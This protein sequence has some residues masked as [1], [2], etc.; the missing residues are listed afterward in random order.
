MHRTLPIRCRLPWL[1]VP[2]ALLLVLLQ[3]TPVVRILSGA[4]EYVLASPAGQILRAAITAAALGAMHSRA[5]ATTFIQ[6]PDNPVRG[7]VGTP[8]QVA[9]TYN[10]TPSPP[11]SF[12]VSGTLPP[13][14]RFIPAAALGTIPSGTPAI[15]G[16]PTQ[17]GTFTVHVQ[18]FNAE[19]L[20]NNVQQS[21]EF[22]ITGGTTATAP[23]IG[24]HPQSQTVAP[25]ASV[26]FSVT[27]TGDPPLSYQWQ[28][29]G[30]NL[31]G[32][33][34]ATLALSNVQPGDAGAYRVVV[35]NSAGSATSAAATLAVTTGGAG[36][37]I[38][39]QPQSQTIAGGSTVVFTVAATDATAF[40]WR[41]DGA[42][43]PG[44]TSPM[45]VISGATTAHAGTY[46]CVVTG[47]GG[48]VTSS[49]AVLTVVNTLDFGRLINLSISTAVSAA[50]PLFTVGTVIGGAGTAGAKP[51]LVR[52]VG[53]ALGVFGVD[54]VLADP[55]LE[56]FNALA[57]KEQENERWGG[58]AVLTQAFA[59]VGAFPFP[60][61]S[62][63]AAVF[64]EAFQPGGYTV[65][66]SGAGGTAG[67]V[68]AEV[69]DA[70][71]AVAF[72]ASVPRLI[73]VSVRKQIDAGSTL[74]AG[75]VIGGQTARTVL[76]RAIG[77]G[78]EVF[79]VEGTMPDP[80]MALFRGTVQIAEND[81]WG[82]DAQLT[83][84]AAAVGAFPIADSGSRDAMLL[85]TLAPG[86]YT[87]QVNA[88]GAGGSALVEVYEV[89]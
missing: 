65:Q 71:P 86:N 55:K 43:L 11:A 67:N 89:P 79:G 70:T 27:A 33:T 42:A 60:D 32:A 21:I 8:L 78:L 37:A 75:F 2:V 39:A 4:G 16:T 84:A 12:Q 13:G 29:D 5:G 85:I 80:R 15:E 73:N 58:S 35:S 18:G 10:G 3:R 40:Q 49:D 53:P 9:F 76:V 22:Q 7:T 88:V 46:T 54:G 63:D 23:S 44:A 24:A 14:L 31:A 45:L 26:T 28:K 36:P 34:Q 87:A 77:P 83:S 25:G 30:T 47:G 68:L 66:V 69:Y 72:T 6:S 1:N 19:G 61:G 41:R 82:G 50:D 74:T 81:N 57:A 56:L 17:A 62:L 20:T 38:A 59:R 52:A 64:S 48:A 51:L